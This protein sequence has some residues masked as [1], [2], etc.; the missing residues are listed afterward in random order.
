MMRAAKVASACLT[1]ASATSRRGL[2]SARGLVDVACA[3]GANHSVTQLAGF[4]SDGLPQLALTQLWVYNEQIVQVLP[5]WRDIL[6][7]LIVNRHRSFSC[8]INVSVGGDGQIITEVASSS[9]KKRALP[10]HSSW[11]W[12]ATFRIS[13]LYTFRRSKHH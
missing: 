13:G 5:V 10:G 9:N 2:A 8:K 7:A 1:T 12:S 3:V 6:A 4:P 11:R